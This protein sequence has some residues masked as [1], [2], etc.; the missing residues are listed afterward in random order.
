MPVQDEVDVGGDDLLG[1]LRARCLPG[2]RGL[3]PQDGANLGRLRRLANG[4][5]IANGHQAGAAQC[6]AKRGQRRGADEL[7]EELGTVV[8]RES[9]RL[10][11]LV[12]ELVERRCESI[13]PAELIELGTVV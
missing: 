3:S 13:V 9:P 7:Y 1:G 2:D 8:G 6:A 11:V 10:H 5:P 4:H 12:S